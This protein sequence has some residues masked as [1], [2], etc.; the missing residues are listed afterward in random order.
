[1]IAA[2]FVGKSAANM[3][4]RP[5]FYEWQNQ[6]ETEVFPLF[7][8]STRTHLLIRCPKIHFII[9]PL[10]AIGFKQLSNLFRILPCIFSKCL[11]CFSI[12]KLSLSSLCKSASLCLAL[13]FKKWWP[14]RHFITVYGTF[15]RQHKMW[16]CRSMTWPTGPPP[17]MNYKKVGLI[18]SN[19]PSKNYGKKGSDHTRKFR[20]LTRKTKLW[21]ETETGDACLS[22]IFFPQFCRWQ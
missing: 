1:M 11:A 5:C 22:E 13:F 10:V 7:R 19:R 17:N 14:S 6:I 21:N 8:Y 4:L 12:F 15:R 20:T 2:L 18:C 9:L 3:R 16:T